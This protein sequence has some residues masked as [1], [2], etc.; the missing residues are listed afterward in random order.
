MADEV[1]FSQRNAIKL[2]IIGFLT[3]VA[4]GSSVTLAAVLIKQSQRHRISLE[5]KNMWSTRLK[6][7]SPILKVAGPIISQIIKVATSIILL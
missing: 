2:I 5:K 1:S 7:C 4:I 6:E 3:F